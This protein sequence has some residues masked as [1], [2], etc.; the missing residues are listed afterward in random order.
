[1]Q[2]STLS[3]EIKVGQLILKK[4]LTIFYYMYSKLTWLHKIVHKICY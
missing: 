4:N 3:C 1:M 2:V